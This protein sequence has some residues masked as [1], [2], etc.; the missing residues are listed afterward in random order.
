MRWKGVPPKGHMFCQ[1]RL[2]R[3]RK[4]SPRPDD[5]FP[6]VWQMMSDASKR[7]AIAAWPAR[8]D[9]VSTAR[10]RRGLT[11]HD[12]TDGDPCDPGDGALAD[13]GDTKGETCALATESDCP[14][15]A[16]FAAAVEAEHAIDPGSCDPRTQWM[17][18]LSKKD[19]RTLRRAF[20]R[21]PHYP[22]PIAGMVT[23]DTPQEGATLPAV[24]EKPQH[25]VQGSNAHVMSDTEFAF[26]HV[27]EPWRVSDAMKIPEA[28]A[29][30]DAEWNK[31]VS[32]RA[33]DM[34][35]V[36]P[37]GEV[38][39]EARREGRTVHIARLFQLIGLK[40]S[41]LAK[42]HQKW[43]GRVVFQGNNVRDTD[44]QAAVFQDLASSSSLMSASKLGIFGA[45]PWLHS[46][47]VRRSLGVY[48]VSLEQR[49]GYASQRRGYQHRGNT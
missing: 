48:A 31:L 44:S 43:K 32:K 36:R 34:L 11:P 29:A 27:V 17:E 38:Q 30:L 39:K 4:G 45:P 19:L 13:P 6:E 5:I 18:G 3:I 24:D 46:R 7:A 41:E 21:L 26:I 49:P 15:L 28:R 35:K 12:R 10:I 9:Q 47:A 2:T 14:T 22:M 8:R 37:W 33:F 23:S 1:G 25:R 16:A 42:K 20:N 40:H